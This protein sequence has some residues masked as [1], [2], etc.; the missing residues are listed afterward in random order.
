ME[1]IQP[2]RIQRESKPD[3]PHQSLVPLDPRGTEDFASTD[4]KYETATRLG[5]VH[6]VATA[7]SRGVSKRATINQ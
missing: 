4:L 6:H 5:C 1:K 7:G 3:F 2:E